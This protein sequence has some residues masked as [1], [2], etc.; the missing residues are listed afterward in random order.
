MNVDVK[1]QGDVCVVSPHGDIKIGEGDLVLRDAVH[2]QI[3]KGCRKVVLDLGDVRYMDSAGIGEV[4]AC[5]KRVRESGGDMKLA[6]LN[7]RLLDLFNLT[8]LLLIFQVHDNVE[9]A[10]KSF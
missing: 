4:V 1:T 6:G 8:R 7:K 10:A 5:L 2:Q 3:E 9:A